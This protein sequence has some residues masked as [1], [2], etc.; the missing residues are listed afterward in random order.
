MSIKEKLNSKRE[1]IVYIVLFFWIQMG[2]LSV[3]YDR[4]LTD[5]SVYFLSL[6]GFVMSYIFGESVRKSSD[7]SL[8][9][10]GKTSKRELM[11]YIVLLIWFL[12]GNWILYTDGDIIGAATYFGAL[13]PFVGAYIIGETYK[14][15]PDDSV[16]E[17]ID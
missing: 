5:L 15:E 1:T 16:D 17:I 13:T 9:L 8:F 6:T 12:L 7:S 14:Q 4:N 2:V 10:A 3:F 11:M